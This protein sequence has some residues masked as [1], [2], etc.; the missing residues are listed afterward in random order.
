M[1]KRLEFSFSFSLVLLILRLDLLFIFGEI[2][3]IF[4]FISQIWGGGNVGPHFVVSW[5]QT[6]PHFSIFFTSVKSSTRFANY[7]WG[8]FLNFF[9]FISH[10]CNFLK[11]MV[12]SEFCYIVYKFFLGWFI[13]RKTKDNLLSFFCIICVNFTFILFVRKFYLS[14]FVLHLCKFFQ[15]FSLGENYFPKVYLHYFIVRASCF[16]HLVKE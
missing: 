3:V 5:T 10:N 2:F 16:I 13:W 4:S 15:S 12:P 11:A 8:N 1:G 14:R 7:F 6:F 9:D